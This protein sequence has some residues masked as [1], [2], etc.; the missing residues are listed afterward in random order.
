MKNMSNIKIDYENFAKTNQKI[1]KECELG[2]R[3]F[4]KTGR[5]ILG[6]NVNKFENK[7]SEF[8]GA[9]YFVGVASGY[10]AIYMSLMAANLPKGAHVLV[11][12]N[13]YIASI[14]PIL[15]LGLKPILVEPDINTYNIDPNLIE[16]K[17][18]PKTKAI[19]VVHLYGKCCNM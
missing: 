6:E 3:K 15:Q 10:D 19:I 11:P 8:I 18:T 9:K 13:T 5:Y 12:A 16:E 4:L 2:F 14:L 17:I 7:F 1:F